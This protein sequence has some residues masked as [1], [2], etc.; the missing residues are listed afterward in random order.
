M[1]AT[2]VD[3][4]FTAWSFLYGD[5]R[6][7]ITDLAGA[8]DEH[9]V[10]GP[11]GGAARELARSSGGAVR[12][13]LARSVQ[14]L[15]DL[16]LGQ[17]LLTGWRKWTVLTAAARRTRDQPG[18]SEVVSLAEHTVTVRQQP[19]VDL[20]VREMR[21]ATLHVELTVE[22]TVRGLAATVRG[23][24]LVALT[25]GSCTVKA[26]LALEERKVAERKG[27]IR[28]P[29][30]VHVGAGIPLLRAS[31][32]SPAEPPPTKTD[33]A[34][35]PEPAAET[36]PVV[37]VEPAPPVEPAVRIEPAAALDPGLV[38]HLPPRRRGISRSP[39]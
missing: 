18:T 17:L 10:L 33:P 8:I 3:E 20:L 38:I 32:G 26:T 7:A 19:S 13:E 23:G 22:F 24:R 36:G 4:R 1:D 2:A 25:G 39:R 9:G 6:D 35:Q 31:D 16:D 27:E 37:Q 29:L 15:L 11:A 28:P 12:A 30:L 5:N 14:G 34:P 21:L